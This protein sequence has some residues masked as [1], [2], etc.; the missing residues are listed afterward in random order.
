MDLTVVTDVLHG[1][2]GLAQAFGV[3]RALIA[4]QV[5]ALTAD[6]IAMAA[7]RVSEADAELKNHHKR[8][9]QLEQQ[10]SYNGSPLTML[11][12]PQRP[13]LMGSETLS[14]NQ[15]ADAE[16]L[17]AH[18]SFYDLLCDQSAHI[19]T[20]AAEL[21]QARQAIVEQKNIDR[22]K[23]LIMQQWQLT[24]EQAYRRL[25]KSAMDQNCRL[26]DVAEKVVR[27]TSRPVATQR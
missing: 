5:E 11:F 2:A 13:G 27:A 19:K 23:L 8:L 14:D 25:Q 3:G 9:K 17:S 22:A 1:H 4:E 18:R 24:E 12:D 16:N 10:N 26:A 20:M 6:L 21:D 15:V 7:H